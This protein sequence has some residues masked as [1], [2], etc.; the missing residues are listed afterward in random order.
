[1]E[2][3]LNSSP[4]RPADLPDL[5]RPVGSLSHHPYGSIEFETGT[6]HMDKWLAAALD[7]LPRYIE[8]Q[9]RLSE[10]PGC[11]IAVA[12]KGSSCS[13][14]RSAMPIWWRAAH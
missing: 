13:S 1:M 5:P 9:V 11:A 14:R 7:Y 4:R 2:V 6:S 12:Y 3:N 8:H 10:Q